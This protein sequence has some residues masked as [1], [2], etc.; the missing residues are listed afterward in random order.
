MRSGADEVQLVR[1][2]QAG[3]REAFATLIERHLPPL[4]AS[5]RRMVGRGELAEEAAHEAVIQAMLGLGSLRQP[6][7]F[8][9]WLVGI[10]L[11]V[12]RHLLRRR[13]DRF[14][15]AEAP[16]GADPQQL[17]EAADVEARVRRAV[18]ALPRGQREAVALFYLAGLS[19][20][21]AAAELGIEVG[22]VK[23]RLHKARAALRKR[24]VE[25]QEVEMTQ[26]DM[27]EVKVVDVLRRK[28][29]D[30]LPQHVI[31][32]EEVGG[33]RRLNVWVGQYEAEQL[34]ITLEDLELVRPLT[35]T[36]AARLLEAARATLDE[37]RIS[38]LT[39]EVF[40]AEAVVASKGSPRTVDARPS[41]ALNLAMV[42]GRPV[43]VAQDVLEA[44]QGGT[45]SA[46]AETLAGAQTAA[47]IVDD[48]LARVP[49]KLRTIRRR[50]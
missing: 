33:E 5:C 4:I 45:D 14:R 3:D 21:E 20:R 46:I 39:G 10:G 13:S 32:L 29:T 48:L 27:V 6:D 26:A 42:L 2:A 16:D 12:C 47:Q 15:D 37:V 49:E 9:A 19:Q 43:R 38:R 31:V 34:A 8:G 35:Y 24:L 25:F 1:A 22:A 44:G 28:Q 18:G 40:Y 30:D 50:A 41:D 11:N 7:R 17:A 36:F 23:G